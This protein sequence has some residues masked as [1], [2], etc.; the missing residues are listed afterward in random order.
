MRALSR[1]LAIVRTDCLIRF[2]RSSTVVIFL[3]LCIA[4]YL[5]IPDP[6]TG[7]ALMQIDE[8]R[9]LYNSS[10]LSIAT[11]S[12]C[13][14]LLG[15]VGFYM[16][17]NS[18]QRDVETRT[19]FVLAS[20]TVRNAE[21]L[22]GKFLGNVAFLAAVIAAFMV[23]SM[24]M[25]LIRGEAPLQPH[26]FLLHYLLLVPPMVVTVSVLA[27]LFECIRFLSGRFGDVVYFFLW[28]FLITIVI[29]STEKMGLNWAVYF[30][31]SGFGF[32]LK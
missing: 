5:W 28:S 11:A 22:A 18:L 27:I 8:R 26:V 9:A 25:Q 15:W 19:G 14:I 17:S 12:L 16:V 10:A 32:M 30:D 13:T 20:T 7:R 24:V 6:A 3:L 31:V 4:A 1:I 21:Y 23:S 2:R 29:I